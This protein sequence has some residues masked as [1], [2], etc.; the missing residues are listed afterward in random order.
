MFSCISSLQKN[1]FKKYESNVPIGL[2]GNFLKLLFV[3][4]NKKNKKSSENKFE[5]YLVLVF[6]NCFYS[7]IL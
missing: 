3:L 2:F 5:A 7:Q 4:K 6:L 1:S